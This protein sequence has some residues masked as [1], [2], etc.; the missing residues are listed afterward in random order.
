MAQ[1]RFAFI[2]LM[3]F[4]ISTITVGLAQKTNI[5]EI[6]PTDDAFVVAGLNDPDDVLGLQSRNTGN[7]TFQKIWYAW[8]VAAI[9]DAQILSIGYLNFDLSELNATKV[10]SAKLKMYAQNVTLT[11]PSRL[12]DVHITGPL[13][14]DE[15]T[16]VYTKAPTFSTNETDS[17]P[18]SNPETWYQW[19][20]TSAVK[21]NAGSN[22]SL[23]V[24]FKKLLDHNEEFVAFASKDSDDPTLRPKLVIETT[25]VT[26]PAPISDDSTITAAI[27][28]AIAAGGIGGIIIFKKRKVQKTKPLS[29]PIQA[30]C[31]NCKKSISSD[32]NICPYC[33]YNLKPKC[34]NCGKLISREFKVCPYC[35]YRV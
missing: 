18:I 31:P 15:S 23:A 28:A 21:E 13:P 24:I 3:I 16:L 8:N 22:L 17:T 27:I 26:A 5:I 14:W 10:S 34:K 11:A 9:P 32:F 1:K 30:T 7:F 6:T 33:E 29:K 19:N 35:E 4:A 25:I 2:V 20:L 12:V